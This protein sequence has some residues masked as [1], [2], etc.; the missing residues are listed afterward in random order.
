MRKIASITA[1]LI[2]AFSTIFL[3]LPA[4]ADVI[5]TFPTTGVVKIDGQGTDAMGADTF[6]NRNRE[7]IDLHNT[8]PTEDVNITGWRTED[9]WAFGDNSL[10]SCNTFK[11]STA[12]TNGLAVGSD[13]ILPAGHT[14]RVYTGS[15]VPSTSGTFHRSFQNSPDHCGAHGHYWTNNADDAYLRDNAPDH[16]VVAHVRYNRLGGYEVEY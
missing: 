8:S 5:Q 9:A 12:N 3:A 10:S 1:A 14:V 7:F 15:G 11:F 2:V 6:L 13:V 16:N 4:G